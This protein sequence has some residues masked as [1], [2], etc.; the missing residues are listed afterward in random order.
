MTAATNKTVTNEQGIA[1][2]EWS[3]DG[4]SC[5][6]VEC[7]GEWQV[8]A[9]YAGSQNFQASPNNI[10]F[11]VDYKAAS[12]VEAKGFFSPENA[13]AFSIVLMAL[14]VASAL[15]Y[16]R[17]MSRRQVQSLRG[18]LTDT[19]MQLEASNEYIKIIFDCYKLSLIHISEPTRPY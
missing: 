10:T 6:G 17:V 16:R 4:R 3:F 14:L 9:V 11:A 15:Y 13:M 19:M 7:T 12:E 1:R 8:I 5:D 2:F 18:I